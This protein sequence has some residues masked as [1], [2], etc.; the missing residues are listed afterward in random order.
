MNKSVQATILSILGITILGIGYLL[1]DMAANEELW[2][3]WPFFFL[4][5][6]WA[7]Y[8]IFFQ[9]KYTKNGWRHLGLATLSGVLLSVSFPPIPMTFFI[10]AAFVPLLKIEKEIAAGVNDN[11]KKGIFKFAY[12]SFVTWNILTTWWVANTAFFASFIAIWLNAFF[13]AIPFMLF[14]WTKR[15]LPKFG[16]ASLIFYWLAF[17]YIHL[18]WEISWTWLNLG[19]AFAEFP[20][21]IQW[22][23]FTGVPGGTFWI[24]ATNILIFKLFEKANWSVKPMDYINKYRVDWIKVK[25]FAIV[26]IFISWAMYF[27]HED[28]G[29]DV[30]V[31]VV[32]P[33]Y[34]AHYE[35][36]RAPKQERQRRF[37]RLS[38]EKL[39]EKTEYLVFPETSF[40]HYDDRLINNESDIRALRTLFNDYPN[41]KIVTGIIAYHIFKENESH[42]PAVREQTR[43]GQTIFY[44]E[45]N[46][47][48]Q[49]EKSQNNLPLYIKSKLV[50]GAEMTPYRKIFSFVTPLL[51]HLGGSVAGHGSQPERMAFESSSGKV[52]P[53]ICYE[54]VY[55]DYHTGFIRDGAEAIFIITNDGW[56]D[57]SAGHKQH[58]KYASLRAIETRRSVARSA[59]M[60]TSCFINQRGDISQPTEYGIEGSVRGTIK[61][62]NEMTFYVRYG[63]LIGRIG[64]FVSVLLLLNLIAKKYLPKK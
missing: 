56:W 22:Y 43:N 57:N 27:N 1:Y 18:R 47:A 34:E 26:P 40:W 44:E 31:V 37:L 59:N 46:A 24:L 61:F 42:S 35:K 17:E 9:K 48:I 6:L 10:F 53:V 64:L 63:D 2:A 8:L 52:A 19:N 60:G 38:K 41:L 32:Q 33:N 13:M 3:H 54:S 12:H 21:W 29:R 7:F 58:L 30:E 16:Y 62:N 49:L 20:S 5:S 23:E 39:T 51:D 45:R 4:V 55:G 15:R 25:L 50:P 28:N 11:V 14:V 36:F